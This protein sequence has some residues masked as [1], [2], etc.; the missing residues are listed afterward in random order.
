MEKIATL[1]EPER[2][3][4]FTETAV[5]LNISP[6]VVEKDFWVSWTLHRLFSSPD[7]GRRIIFKGG[8]SLSKVYHLIG[9][10]SEDIDLILDWRLL[11]LDI[12]KP[13]DFTSR[14]QQNRILKQLEKCSVEFLSGD[15]F[16]RIGGLLAPV[17]NCEAE[18]GNKHGL[19]I[20]YPALFTSSYLRSNL[21]LEIGPLA[22]WRPND[23]RSIS[24]MA[25]EVFPHVFQKPETAVTVI[26]PERTFWEKV[27]IL[28]S[29]AFRPDNKQFP[30]RYSRHYY[31][32][33]MISQSPVKDLALANGELLQEVV[34]FKQHFYPCT[35]A[36]YELAKPPTIRL[37]PE[38]GKL[39]G[40]RQDY[41]AMTEMFFL[42]PPS[43]F[44]LLS[45]LKRLE[46]EINSPAVRNNTGL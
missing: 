42:K 36:N 17:C 20:V 25:S 43:F 29:E 34:R 40:L 33:M 23:R 39:S 16:P 4:L 26:R 10:F 28:H 15:F 37:L 2:R 8:T 6:M 31:D 3:D 13:G 9:R 7:I 44:D 24:P 22:A 27:T 19:R 1:P 45:G 46:Q 18:V 21:L 14:N 12:P 5:R 35:W 30:H 38:D 32:V 41:T 11:G